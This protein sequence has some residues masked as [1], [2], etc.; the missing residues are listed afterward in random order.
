MTPHEKAVNAIN[1]RLERLQ[2]N[3]R[4]AKGEGAQGV[5]VQS[6]VVTIGV[7]E[8]LNDYFKA[9]GQYAQRRH[10]ELKQ[11]NESL[12]A[13]HAELL[14]SGKELLEKLKAAPTDRAIRK[15][16]DAT[17]QKMAAIQ[18]TLRRGTNALQR[19]LALSL[20]MIDEM[21]VTVRRFSEA[22]EPVALKRV[23]KTVVGQVYEYYAAHPA[24]PGKDIVDPV[25]WE[26]S[27]G[28]ELE[29]ANDFYDGYSRAGF[30]VILALELMTIA[31][32][33]RPPQTSEETAQRAREAVTTRLKQIAARF[34]G[35]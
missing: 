22:D 8:A 3:L 9:I 24:V 19:E 23:L 26:K 16:I 1:A 15:E 7:A 31:V 12:A 2:A 32:S 18:K 21:A 5:L 13:Q 17:Q 30:Q 29:Q 14:Q 25:A 33:D 6:V 20:R 34:G 4:E 10:G 35:A 27:A 28:A 11:T